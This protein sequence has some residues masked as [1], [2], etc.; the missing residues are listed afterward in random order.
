MTRTGTRPA[1]TAL[2]LLVASAAVAFAAP[3]GSAQAAEIRYV[4]NNQALTNYD[5]ER[6]VAFLRLQRQGGDLQSIAAEQMVDQTLRL[7][8]MKRL[9]VNVDETMVDDAYARF[10]SS[11]DIS[12]SQLDTA[13]SEAGVT[14]N[15]FRDFIRSQIGWSRVL[16][17]RFQSTGEMSEQE[18]VQRM[19]D[20]GGEKPSA[21]EYML[22]QVIFVVPESERS[23]KLGQRERE[24]RSMRDRF[25]GCDSTREFATGLVDVT[26]RDLGRVLE[27]ELPGDWREHIVAIGPGETTPVRQTDRGVEFIGVC[28]TREVSDDRVAQMVFQTEDSNEEQVEEMTEEY[29]EEL[30]ERSE[31]VER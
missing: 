22:Q 27:P 19:L 28:S 24:A 7:Q 4:I 20:Q 6:R 9:N 31:I 3:V 21:T 17:A 13:L 23:A 29:M 10:A 11:N 2:I 15:H 1:A 30:R 12:T 5:I 14:K 25:Q 16:Q 8:E 26:V 18:A